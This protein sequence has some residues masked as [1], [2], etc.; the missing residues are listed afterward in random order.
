MI[1]CSAASSTINGPFMSKAPEYRYQACND[2]FVT[3]YDR[4]KQGLDLHS[5][6][7][8]NFVAI[9]P[10]FVLNPLAIT[11]YRCHVCVHS[12]CRKLGSISRVQ[13]NEC[14]VAITKS[15]HTTYTVQTLEPFHVIYV[16]RPTFLRYPL[17]VLPSNGRSRRFLLA[18][19]SSNSLDKTEESL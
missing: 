11:H 10:A 7:L 5:S 2:S 15:I 17:A 19:C 3:N 14:C 18:D 8:F 16:C 1:H 4:R 12:I 9:C 13:F 6:Y